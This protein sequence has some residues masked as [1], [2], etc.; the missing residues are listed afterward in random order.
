MD[1]NLQKL[2]DNGWIVHLMRNVTR[3]YSAYATRRGQSLKEVMPKITSHD[4]ETLACVNEGK[5]SQCAHSETVDAAIEQ[6]C[7]QLFASGRT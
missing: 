7:E 3:G 4:G 2:L 5:P 6:V 1:T